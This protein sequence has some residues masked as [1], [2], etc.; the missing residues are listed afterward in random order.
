MS[1]RLKNYPDPVHVVETHGADAVRMYMC[2]SPVVRAEPLKFK[3]EGVK[4]VVKDVFL[5]WFNAY[6]FFIQESFRYEVDGKK[7]IPDVKKIKASKNYMDK[8]IY[9]S[10]QSLIAFVREEMEAYRLY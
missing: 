1:K 4:D 7:F 9:S 8:W 2:N 5:P 10:T 6:R 3:E